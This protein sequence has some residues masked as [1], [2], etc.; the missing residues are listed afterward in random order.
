MTALDDALEAH[1]DATHETRIASYKDFLRI[2]S[3]SGIPAHADDCRR[4]ATW[5]AEAMRTAGIEH[6]EVAETGGHPVVYGDWLHAEGAPTILVYGHY[7][8]QPVDPLDLWTS[9]PF[10][11]VVV[12]GRMLARGAADDKGQIHL[13]VMAAAAILATRGALPG[14]RP[15]PLRGRGG[16]ELGPP[17]SLDGGQPA[18]G[19]T[20]D[21]AIISDSG[22]FEGNIPSITVGLRGIMYAQVDVVGEPRRPPLGQ[23]RR[24]RREPGERPRHDHRRAQGSRRAD[25][26]PGLLRRCGRPDRRRPR[27]AR[28][29]CPSTRRPTRRR[30]ASPALVGEAGLHRAGAARAR[31]RRST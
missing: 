7:D 25:P 16:V 13:H 24:R 8:V 18:S 31:G 10:E 9:P 2:P 15:L 27:G 20:A 1:L 26:G 21:V 17:R 23:L 6:V 12:D 28:G 11:P 29:S 14:Q 4:A 3:I 5:L 19:S 22:F 30:S